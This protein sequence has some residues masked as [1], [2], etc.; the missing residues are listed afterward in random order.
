MSQDQ[1]CGAARTVLTQVPDPSRRISR[2]E[3]HGRFR[4][5]IT[6]Q[7]VRLT[8]AE[9]DSPRGQQVTDWVPGTDEDLRLV[10]PQ[11]HGLVLRDLY[12]SVHLHQVCVVV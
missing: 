3:T 1:L 12:I 9:G 6:T 8:A 7:E 4:L 11:D 2:P 10:A 5:N